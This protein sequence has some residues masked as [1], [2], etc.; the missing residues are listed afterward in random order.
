MVRNVEIELNNETKDEQGI[1]WEPSLQQ[2]IFLCVKTL[3]ISPYKLVHLI[4]AHHQRS[5]HTAV[6][7]SPSSQKAL[8][9]E[10]EGGGVPSAERP[11]FIQP[12][13]RRR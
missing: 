5:S 4:K 1:K 12:S 3:I 9:F 11:L 7:C 6:S 13:G 2:L 8:Y 10:G